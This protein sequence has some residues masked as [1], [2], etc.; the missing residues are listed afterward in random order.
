MAA[1]PSSVEIR[2]YQVGFGDCFLLSFVYE[3]KRRHVLIDFG[4]T[5]VPK[6]KKPRAARGAKARRAKRKAKPALTLGR[7]LRRVADDIAAVCGKEGLTAIVA[8]H[9]HAD[10]INGFGTEGKTGRSGEVIKALKPRV[11]LQPWTEDPDAKRNATA[12]TRDTSRSARGFVA[13]LAAMNDIAARVARLASRP[14]SWMSASL[15]KELLFLGLD[16]IANRSAV[17]NL[18]AMGQ[19]KGATA[20]WAH[21]GSNAGL[22]RLL[23][24]VRVHVLGPPNLRQSEKIRKMRSRDPDQFW[25]LVAGGAG[26]RGDQAIA[27]ARG[28]GRVATPVPSE[29]RWFRD[30]LEKLNGEQILEIVRTLDQ[31]MNNTSL[32]LLFEVLGQKLL[33]PGDAQVENWS[34]ALEDAPDAKRTRKL[35]AEVDVYKVGHHGSLNATPKKSLWENFSKRKGKRLHT[36]LSTAAGKHGHTTS[37]TEVPRRTLLTALKKESQLQSTADLKF[38]LDTPPCHCLK[39]TRSGAAATTD[40][41]RST[42]RRRLRGNVSPRPD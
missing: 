17:D 1:Q 9:R 38:G 25:Q 31:Q 32:I 27:R 42:R 26:S 28:R 39:L 4:S 41:V 8:T 16:N 2:T 29:A 13:G 21:H 5:G 18:I 10:H 15:Q 19:R 35:L 34:F 36:L 14:P 30:R 37:N 3:K 11:V 7:H 20:V 23:P 40:P 33:F 12:A 6:A 24:G 22:G